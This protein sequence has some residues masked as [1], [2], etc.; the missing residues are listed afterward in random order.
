MEFML[1][2]EKH[3]EL[4]RALFTRIRE[5]DRFIE[6]LTKLGFLSVE[7]RAAQVINS[8]YAVMEHITPRGMTDRDDFFEEF[9]WMD[10][11]EEFYEKWFGAESDQEEDGVG[12]YRSFREELDRIC[13]PAIIDKLKYVEYIK[14]EG[15]TVGM[16][17]GNPGYIDVL[18]VKPEYRRRGLAR[19]AAISWYRKYKQPYE[20]VR[21][22]IITRNF[23]AKK[24][25]SSVFVL[26]ELGSDEVDGLYEI[27]SERT[28]ME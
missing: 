17:G 23:A 16:I 22:H 28:K 10:D 1:T 26:T 12:L 9:A 19:E 14:C 18:Y 7:G 8:S 11:V 21:L 13:A 5:E 2:N 24:F 25:W 20:A 15:K 3:K 6:D 4:V 27:L